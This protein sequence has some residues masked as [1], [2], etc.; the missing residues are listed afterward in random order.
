MNV[1]ILIMM[2]NELF[3]HK[4]YVTE[5]ATKIPNIYYTHITDIQE[6]TYTC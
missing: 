6:I 4:I 1:G 2:F 3:N 5:Q